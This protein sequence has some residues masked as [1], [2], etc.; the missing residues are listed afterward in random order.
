MRMTRI[1]EINQLGTEDAPLRAAQRR[2]ARF[3]NT[4][5]MQT[6]LGA[7]VSDALADGRVVSGVGGQYNFV[8][9]GHALPDARS[10]LLFRALRESGGAVSSSLLGHY[11]H[12][13]IPRHLR[14]VAISEY[15]IADLRD[16]GDADCIRA[17]LAI[18]DARFMPGLAA[19]A[20]E[21][22]KLD[23]GDAATWARNTPQTIERTLAPF[24]RE[25]LLPEYPIGSDFSP[26]E[27]DLVRALGRLKRDTA[28]RGGKARAIWGA[29]LLDE[30]N[31]DACEAA[32][33]ARM[34]FDGREGWREAIERKLLRA[35]L[36]ATRD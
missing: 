19:K 13:T 31:A 12:T 25:G 34:G 17:M 28:N 27:Q 23:L 24:R 20:V 4:T 16:R 3:I 32:A 30:S 5:M 11:G 29:L 10:V 6:V 33:M 14:D 35:A 22:G 18:G 9:M 1:S 8:A 15:G 36:R 2:H 21:A 7:A 26:E